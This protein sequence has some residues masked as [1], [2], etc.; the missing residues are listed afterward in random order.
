MGDFLLGVICTIG[1]L[2][3]IGIGLAAYMLVQLRKAVER[4]TGRWTS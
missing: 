4:A 3:L 1:A 2:A